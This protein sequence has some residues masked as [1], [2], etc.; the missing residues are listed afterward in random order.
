MR[1]ALV[2]LSLLVVSSIAP[3]ARADRSRAARLFR[4]AERL[5]ARGAHAEAADRFEA[6]YAEAPADVALVAATDE[7]L[8]A[9]QWDQATALI[10]ALEASA[11]DPELQTF[12]REAEA[13]LLAA[14]ACLV[15]RC[16]PA[17]RLATDAVPEA[18]EVKAVHRAWL[19]PD[20]PTMLFVAFADGTLV[21]REIDLEAGEHELL[22]TATPEETVD[23][24]EATSA[25]VDAALRPRSRESHARRGPAGWISAAVATLA[26]DA[27]AAYTVV[28]SARAQEAYT[29]DPTIERWHEAVARQRSAVATA[30]TA[31]SVTTATASLVLA[32]RHRESPRVL[33]SLQVVN[34]GAAIAVRGSF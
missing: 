15:V 26:L 27:V 19:V 23:S 21:E 33:P 34:G 6:A 29:S 30:A 8:L 11:S 28:R 2:I 22:V 13:R 9:E 18:G 32:T 25:H 17:C 1:F 5:S 20:R 3:S 14:R 10:E 4:D 31:A 24:D 7:R 16:E 12:L